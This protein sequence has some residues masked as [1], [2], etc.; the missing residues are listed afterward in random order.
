MGN[1]TVRIR[2]L[3]KVCNSP[4]TR[5]KRERNGLYLGFWN[6]LPTQQTNKQRTPRKEGLEFSPL[7]VHSL[8]LGLTK[9]ILIED[10]ADS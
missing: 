7:I 8:Y 9:Y 2:G 5:R 6:W 10:E 4:W 1:R 3:S